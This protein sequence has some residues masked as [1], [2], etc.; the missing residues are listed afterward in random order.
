MATPYSDDLRRKLLEA[1]ERNEGSLAELADRFSVS[2]GWAKKV[3]AHKTRTGK[4]ERD[5]GKPRGPVSKVTAEI[6]RELQGWISKQADL[7]LAEMQLRLYEQRKLEVSVSRLWTVLQR[8][9]MRLKK[10]RSMLPSKTP[11]QAGSGASLGASGARS[12]TRRA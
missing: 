5:L 10:S 9:G 4:M 11:K 7:T 6:Q 2:L 1:Y 3:S 8:L 12:S